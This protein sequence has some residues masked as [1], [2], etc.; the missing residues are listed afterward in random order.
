VSWIALAFCGPVLW[1]L[2]THIDKYLVEKFF[3]TTG[4]GTLL[5]FTSLIGLIGL[6]IIWAFVDVFSIGTTGVI[7][8]SVSGLLYMT[9]MYFYLHALQQEEAT[10]I[11][12][13]FQTSTLFTYAIAYFVLHETLTT[14][15]IAGGL[16]VMASAAVISYD[17]DH[18]RKFK[19]PIV[20][21]VLACTA[22]LAVSAVIF[23]F[24][25][26]KNAF[27]PVTFWTFAGEAVFGAAMLAVPFYR[28]EFMGMFAKHPGAV[29]GINAANELINLGGGLAARWASLLGPVSLVQAIGGTT[30]FFVFLF[31]VLISLFAPRLGREDLSKGSLIQKGI[32]VVLIVAGVTLIGRAGAN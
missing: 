26:I 5:I 21:L 8:T 22:T 19:L 4:V 9:A 28:R 10:T 17:P 14:Q 15:R 18:G 31:G 20:A 2:S 3:K 24:F 27:W 6:P 16:L 23:K 7:V 13:L 32:A 30:S 29:I 1:A 25:A 11:A 12:P